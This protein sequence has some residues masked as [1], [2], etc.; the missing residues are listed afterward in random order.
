MRVKNKEG[1]IKIFSHWLKIIKSKVHCFNLPTGYIYDSFNW[2]KR[3]VLLLQEE[4]SKR[5]ITCPDSTMYWALYVLLFHSTPSRT[6]E[7]GIVS[8]IKK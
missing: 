8:P 1:I 7:V 5:M 4:L 6:Y 3:H 2:P